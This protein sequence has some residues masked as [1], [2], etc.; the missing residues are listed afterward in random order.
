MTD[1]E[2]IRRV[3]SDRSATPR[4]QELARRLFCLQR[5]LDDVDELVVDMVDG[6]NDE[7]R[8]Q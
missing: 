5:A 3:M 2:L 8:V 6:D 4:E 1:D 7:G